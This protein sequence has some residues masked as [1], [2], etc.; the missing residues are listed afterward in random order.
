MNPR[1]GRGIRNPEEHLKQGQSR[2]YPIRPI[3]LRTET[4]FD[5]FGRITSDGVKAIYVVDG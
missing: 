1:E 3:V 5:T 2:V 4:P